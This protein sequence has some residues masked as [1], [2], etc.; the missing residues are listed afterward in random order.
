LDN[1]PDFAMATASRPRPFNSAEMQ[2]RVRHPLQSIR[3]TIRS[4]LLMEGF[5]LSVLYLA[6]GFWVGLALDF[7]LFYLF[8]FD[9]LLELQQ[10]TGNAA[11]VW[12]RAIVL[13]I[14]GVGLATLIVRKVFF[15]LFREFSDQ[16]VA[17]LL[18]KRFPRQ[19]G[20]RLITAVELADPR[21]SE[22]YGFSADMI[23]KTIVEAA[24]RVEQVPVSK[25]FNWGRLY[26][27]GAAAGLATVGMYIVMMIVGMVVIAASSTTNLDA[28]GKIGRAPQ[29]ASVGAWFGRFNGVVGD[30]FQR[31][32]LLQDDYWLRDAYVELIRFHDT[33][34]HPGDM[35]LGRDDV[36][37]DLNVKAFHWVRVDDR[38]A[39]ESRT[40]ADPKTGVERTRLV[41]NH[42]GWRP[43]QWADLDGVVDAATLAEANKIPTDWH[44]WT[45]EV[46]DLDAVVPKNLVP[47]EWQGK[48]FGEI[49]GRKEGKDSATL[50]R[51]FA[52]DQQEYKSAAAKLFNWQAWTV[53]RIDMHLQR[54]ELTDALGKE[55]GSSLAALLKVLVALEEKVNAGDNRGQI[56]LLE[57]PE[58]VRFYYRGETTANPPE[59]EHEQVKEK[60]LYQRK[61]LLPLGELK[62][63]VTFHVQA[64][65]FST[66]TRN[67]TLVPPTSIK[68]L[69]LQLEEPAY[70]HH[71]IQGD[72]FLLRG[73]MQRMADQTATVTGDTSTILVKYGSDLKL[74]AETD[75]P[76][77]G[78]VLLTSPQKAEDKAAELPKSAPVVAEGGKSFSM[79]FPHVTRPYE[80]MLEFNDE[81][82]VKGRR[83]ILI[84]PKVDMAPEVFDVEMKVFLRKPRIK[85]DN[86]EGGSVLVDLP[87]DAFLI[88]PDAELPFKAS[89]K[90][91]YGLTSAYWNYEVQ[92]VEFELSGNAGEQ[93]KAP[94]VLGGSATPR[95]TALVAT[96]L[97][98]LPG[99]AAPWAGAPYIAG[100]Q[101]LLDFDLK[102]GPEE[103]KIP[104]PSFA[105]RMGDL[106]LHDPVMADLKTKLGIPTPS[107]EMVRD[108]QLTDFDHFYLNLYLKKLKSEDPRRTGQLHYQLKLSLEAVD[109]NIETG[110]GVGKSKNLLTF[111][112]VSENELLA[113]IALEEESLRDSLESA[114]EKIK[115]AETIVLDVMRR[116]EGRDPV[117]FEGMLIRSEDANSLISKAASSI[118]EAGNAYG[119][120]AL[121][122]RYNNIRKDRQGQLLDNI[123]DPLQSIVLP[124]GEL[125]E[126]EKS[127]TD[128]IARM[129]DDKKRK[130]PHGPEH[131]ALAKDTA[132]KIEL[133]ADKLNRILAQMEADITW[134][135]SLERLITIERVQRDL[136]QQLRVFYVVE[137]DKLFKLLN[138]LK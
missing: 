58:S 115:D 131:A 4:Y 113:Q 66:A 21:S 89:L 23:Q 94:M 72:P 105:K 104:L 34:K 2:R 46:D 48:T 22:R 12:F 102:N 16:S 121:E 126:I 117:Q 112:V 71:R 135:R 67:V 73:K 39:R 77:K 78:K 99:H 86:K 110:P 35:R 122:M 91:D 6:A 9:W 65:D 44:G 111:L 68:K 83:R 124:G 88:T 123:L 30:W 84:R 119:R 107:T 25:V 103:G 43:L 96:G 116:F 120:I 47:A 128:L 50:E 28:E 76:I 19:L 51:F 98:F 60:G 79:T 29:P 27:L 63:S 20:D 57:V 114:E 134:A 127:F 136:V 97:Q 53:D 33:P 31:E 61:Y 10:I 130:A 106:T 95:R 138:D 62:E 90:D 70:V 49:L 81:D 100:L 56:R 18:E 24:D 137:Q 101:Q 17:L 13:T 38:P 118:R 129:E 132:D 52:L 1:E 11:D 26:K 125:S 8:R 15:R 3:G 45:V 40:F 64:G 109:T 55:H 42:F 41:R 85:R 93:P 74:I 54:K 7:G 14:Y 37:P 32:V 87:I 108:H 92:P 69:T 80:F 5:F 133:L 75:R 59:N 82:N 36:K